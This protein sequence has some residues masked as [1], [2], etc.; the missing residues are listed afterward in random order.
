MT[1]ATRAGR[2]IGGSW[3][4]PS[5]RQTQDAWACAVMV[6][7]ITIY[8]RALATVTRWPCFP[9]DPDP[10]HSWQWVSYHCN[11]R[12]LSAELRIGQ[13]GP[14]RQ[15]LC[16]ATSPRGQRVLAEE[17]FEAPWGSEAL[18]LTGQRRA[19][20]LNHRHQQRGR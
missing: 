11:P 15:Q 8:M 12:S 16:A 13:R 10:R 14:R 20:C 1:T 2:H 19:R 5:I 4:S 17:P 18:A 9:C 7:I 3:G 6:A